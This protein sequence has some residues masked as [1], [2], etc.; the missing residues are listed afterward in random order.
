[1][2]HVLS[3]PPAGEGAE[4]FERV[5]TSQEL[6]SKPWNRLFYQSQES[7]VAC[8]RNQNSDENSMN[9]PALAGISISAKPFRPVQN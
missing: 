7:L 5:K 1:M 8:P 9:L 2:L 6:C 3:H 4:R